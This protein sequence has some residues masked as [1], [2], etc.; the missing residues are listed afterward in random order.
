[1]SEPNTTTADTAVAA[2]LALEIDS[3]GTD[4]D[5]ASMLL[6]IV[7]LLPPVREWDEDRPWTPVEDAISAASLYVEYATGADQVYPWSDRLW[8]LK[9]RLKRDLAR[10]R[11]LL[12]QE[13]LGE[14][15]GYVVT[16]RLHDAFSEI[17]V[18]REKDLPS[19]GVM[20]LSVPFDVTRRELGIAIQACEQ[21]Y[22]MGKVRGVSEVRSPILAA[23]GIV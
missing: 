15:P 20:L 22:A 19:P 13:A 11:E 12:V 1:M 21:G 5:I 4:D 7:A 8:K 2:L 18:W 16:A 6:P 17:A 14:F 23:L 9:A 3:N 10:H